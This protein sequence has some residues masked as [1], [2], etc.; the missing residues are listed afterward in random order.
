MIKKKP[1]KITVKPV[2]RKL[3]TVGK[4][5]SKRMRL[6]GKSYMA[7]EEL[8]EEPSQQEQQGSGQLQ[9]D[10]NRNKRYWGKVS[11]NLYRGNYNN[12]VQGFKL[13]THEQMDQLDQQ[14]V[15]YDIDEPIRDLVIDLNRNGFKTMGSCA[16]HIQNTQGF[17]TLSGSL[18]TLQQSP[19]KLNRLDSILQTHGCK[20]IAISE[21]DDDTIAEFKPMAVLS[22]DKMSLNGKRAVGKNYGVKT[23]E[24]YDGVV[25]LLGKSKRV[26]HSSG[27]TTMKKK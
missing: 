1:S 21:F 8:Y 5:I 25:K 22:W 18:N 13:P 27:K 11:G 23:Q 6:M 10:D 20:N 12:M 26:L 24:Q 3:H 9:R 19:E 7:M 16:G 4:P 2:K 17:V 15:I 14:G